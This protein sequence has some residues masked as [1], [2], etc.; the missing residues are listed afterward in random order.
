MKRK[1]HLQDFKDENC[2][3]IN[4]MRI[5]NKYLIEDLFKHN[6]FDIVQLTFPNNSVV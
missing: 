6:V 3:F 5:L 2:I 4:K 1:A